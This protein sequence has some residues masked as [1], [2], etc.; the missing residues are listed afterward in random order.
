MPQSP[1]AFFLPS[2]QGPLFC[3]FQAPEG[4]RLRGRVLHFHPFAEELNTCRRVS[5]QYAR[6]LAQ[7]GYAVMQFD[8]WGCGDSAGEFEQASWHAW[9]SNARLALR[10]MDE[11]LGHDSGSSKRPPLWFWGV[12]GGALLAARALAAAEEAAHLL[13]WQ[14]SCSGK[15]LLQQ[16]LR[17]QTASQWLSGTPSS[18][19]RMQH[20]RGPW[21]DG[22]S[23]TI[24]GY[25]ISPELAQALGEAKLA[26]P[27]D[28]PVAPGHLVW[29]ESS[30]TGEAEFGPGALRQMDLWS[31]RGWRISN[32]RV[33][34][35][36]FWH[37]ISS[38]DAPELLQAS[39]AL[40]QVA[41][42]AR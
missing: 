12:R 17:T 24:A 9:V 13:L 34:S 25:T 8:M 21:E 23:V 28:R 40:M 30:P 20:A 39:L 2:A 31:S 4:D 41:E 22:K 6:A 7:Q 36:A 33:R 27:D 1:H 35:P 18:T 14:P 10:W 29:L 19:A 15:Q 5:A 16:M 11:R 37:S 32:E 38:E 26:P 3:L 42:T